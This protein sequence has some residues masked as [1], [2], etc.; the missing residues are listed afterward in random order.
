MGMYVI[1]M[2]FINQ[3]TKKIKNPDFKILNSK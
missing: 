2:K 1:Q 3:I